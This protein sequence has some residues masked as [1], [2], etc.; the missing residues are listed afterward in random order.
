MHELEWLWQAEGASGA[1]M[2]KAAK[3]LRGSVS[4]DRSVSLTTRGMCSHDTSEHFRRK[5]WAAQTEERT[6]RNLNSAN[7]KRTA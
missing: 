6:P 7:P 4:V 1:A 5:S 3:L 2:I